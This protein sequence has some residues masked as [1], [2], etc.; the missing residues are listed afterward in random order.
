MAEMYTNPGKYTAILENPMF[1]DK[2]GILH[3]HKEQAK[4]GTAVY[5]YFHG[6]KSK[7]RQRGN[8]RISARSARR[9]RGKEKKRVDFFQNK[10]TRDADC[11]NDYKHR[12]K[13][14][15]RRHSVE[16]IVLYCKLN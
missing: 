12:G 13:C 1:P 7:S 5:D 4:P 2:S 11:V 8:L 10:C 15:I 14:T 16:C 9:R 6:S 3:Y